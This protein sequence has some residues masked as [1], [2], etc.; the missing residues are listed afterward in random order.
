MY[1][2]SDRRFLFYEHD[3][4]AVAADSCSTFTYTHI[5]AEKDAVIARQNDSIHNSFNI[6]D[7]S[8]FPK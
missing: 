1:H 2:L 4:F 6:D 7:D 3:W 8:M 5:A